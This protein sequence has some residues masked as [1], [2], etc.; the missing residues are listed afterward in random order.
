M[1]AVLDM[2]NYQYDQWGAAAANAIVLL[3]EYFVHEELGLQYVLSLRIRYLLLIFP[4][5]D[6]FS[7]S[8]PPPSFFRPSPGPTVSAASVSP[9]VAPSSPT[10]TSPA[11]LLPT[12][13]RL[14]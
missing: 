9:A 10:H 1:V 4:S 14:S 11:T 12:L 6:R 13:P 2:Q 5:S 7:T 8:L 3:G